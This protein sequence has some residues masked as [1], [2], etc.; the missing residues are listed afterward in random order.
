MKQQDDE[1]TGFADSLPGEPAAI[2]AEAG[3]PVIS[4]WSVV[5][6]DRIVGT[7][8]G[9]KG[10][11]SGKTII[12]SPV[13]QILLDGDGPYP[14][15]RTQSGSLYAL[16]EPSATFGTQQAEDFLVYKARPPVG[17]AAGEPTPQMRTTLLKLEP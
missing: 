5:G 8:F 9:H 4:G 3:H 14:L 6:Y 2:A 11:A 10:A 15:A 13:L 17:E 16:A 12:T 7:V 1:K